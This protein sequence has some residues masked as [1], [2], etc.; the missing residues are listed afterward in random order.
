[1]HFKKNETTPKDWR[2]WAA[3]DVVIPWTEAMIRLRLPT[4]GIAKQ[5]PVKLRS[6]KIEEGWLGSIDSGALAPYSKFEGNKSTTSWYPNREI[7]NAWFKFDFQ[8]RKQR[9]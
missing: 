1:M 5:K 8:S 7:A 6:I 4:G 3:N 2:A 9:Q